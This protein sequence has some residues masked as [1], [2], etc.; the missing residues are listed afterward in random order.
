MFLVFQLSPLAKFSLHNHNDIICLGWNMNL[1][2]LLLPI[3]KFLS[4]IMKI[5]QYYVPY[6]LVLKYWAI[7]NHTSDP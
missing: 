3:G 2:F 1:V 7:S 4:Y 5:I 6:A